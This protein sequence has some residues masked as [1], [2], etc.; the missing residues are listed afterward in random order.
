MKNNDVKLIFMETPTFHP[1]N[2]Y[3]ID[4]F[5]NTYKTNFSDINFIDYSKWPIP[6]DEMCDAH[7]LNHKGAVRFTKEIKR[8]YNIK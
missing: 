6:L 4:Y 7:H 5:Y 8:R 2:Y 1:E 3:D